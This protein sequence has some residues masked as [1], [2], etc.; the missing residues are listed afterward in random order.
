MDAAGKTVKVL[1]LD[2]SPLTTLQGVKDTA[3]AKRQVEEQLGVPSSAIEVVSET[4]DTAELKL[5]MSIPDLPGTG[6]GDA[7][8]L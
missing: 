5:T 4:E 6:L 7:G 3:D 8:L 1:A 2:G